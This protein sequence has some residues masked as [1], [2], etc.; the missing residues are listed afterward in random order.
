MAAAGA[1][2]G[3]PEADRPLDGRSGGGSAS[4]R[5]AERQCRSFH[6]LMTEEGAPWWS[7][8]GTQARRRHLELPGG[9]TVGQ[10]RQCLGRPAP[11][12][13]CALSEA[14]SDVPGETVVGAGST[15]RQ[16]AA[17]E[18]TDDTSLWEISQRCR[19][20]LRFASAA[21]GGSAEWAVVSVP[22]GL[23]QGLRTVWSKYTAM[24]PFFE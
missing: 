6:V 4:C 20:E 13:A 23:W 22:R 5:E 21:S 14:R 10:A 16:P 15:E 7:L 12:P 2:P 8:A 24:G 19:A 18:V 3:A 9:S 17:R 11:G 1:P